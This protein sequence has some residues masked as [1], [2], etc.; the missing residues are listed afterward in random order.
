MAVPPLVRDKPLILVVD[1]EPNVRKDLGNFL[2]DY[3]CI[4]LPASSFDGAVRIYEMGVVPDGVIIDV[5]LGQGISGIDLISR[6]NELD[7]RIGIAVLTGHQDIEDVK[8]L[9][10]VQN[11]VR[12]LTKPYE[13]EDIRSVVENILERTEELREGYIEGFSNHF[14]RYADNIGRE[15]ITPLSV[16]HQFGAWLK[17]MHDRMYFATPILFREDSVEGISAASLVDPH[18][19]YET[20]EDSVEGISAASLVDPHYKSETGAGLF[21]IKRYSNN[22][23]QGIL[24]NCRAALELGITQPVPVLDYM[25]EEDTYTYALNRLLPAPNFAHIFGLLNHEGQTELDVRLKEAIV[26]LN[27]EVNAR[28]YDHHR[29]ALNIT[30][31]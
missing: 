13:R 25:D 2:D 17:T 28:W 26:R 14:I 21:V 7:D 9:V 1:D 30:D 19:R 11:V 31:D 10:G 29:P 24:E 12:F 6:L 23:F 15:G 5:R 27:T 8:A 22:E 4:P 16:D 18:Y 3:H 20:R